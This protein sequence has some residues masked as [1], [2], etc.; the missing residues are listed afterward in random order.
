MIEPTKKRLTIIFLLVFISLQLVNSLATVIF[1]DYSVKKTIKA[2]VRESFLKEFLPLYEKRDLAT[3]NNMIEDELFQIFDKQG[4][5]QIAVKTSVKFDPLVNISSLRK[6]I[7]GDEVYETIKDGETSYIMYYAPL[8]DQH[9]SRTTISLELTSGILDVYLKV[10]LL[11][12][13]VLLIAACIITYYLV[14]QSLAPLIRLMTFQET[15]SSNITHELNTPLTGIKG[16]F[17]VILKRERSA[18]EYRETIKSA[19]KSINGLISITN[20]LYILAKSKFTPLELLKER[21]DMNVLISEVVEKFEP[22]IV[23]KELALDLSIAPD[24]FCECDPSLF[25]TA[26]ENILDNAV[27][28]TQKKGVI[29]VKAFKEENNCILKISNTC[30]GITQTELFSFFKPF[31][32]KENSLNKHVEGVGLGLY[33]VQYIIQSHQGSINAQID[34][35]V[36]SFTISIPMQ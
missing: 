15:F 12:L 19:L 17:E 24:L 18:A 21:A 23:S 1:I 29:E 28:Y 27:K 32:R 11:T 10:M 5:L 22:V 20:A 31:F 25:R 6:A 30:S 36:L 14:Q 3:L 34:N 2:H 8:D 33:I 13:P 16:N 7:M 4:E 35:G 9:G 26:T